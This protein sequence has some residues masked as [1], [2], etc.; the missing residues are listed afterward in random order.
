M[1]S[2]LE[3]LFSKMWDSYIVL[4]PKAPKIRDAFRAINPS[5]S[6]DHIALRTL[7]LR[8]VDADWLV[9]V[10]ISEGYQKKQSYNF[11]QKKL[12]AFHLEHPDSSLP[13]V[14]VS[15][16]L[17]EEFSEKLQTEAKL[18]AE[19]WREQCYSPEVRLIAGRTWDISYA[20]Y[21]LLRQ[22]SE[23]AAW[24]YAFG[25]CPNH[26]TISVNQLG[27]DWDL[28]K[29]NK[30]LTSQDYILNTSG[31]EIKGSVEK[32]LKQSS[33]K[34]DKVKVEFTEGSKEILG[35][36]YE[37]AERFPL[38]G[39]SEEFSGFIEGSADKIFESTDLN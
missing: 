29:V 6:N 27:G 32:G 20:T 12:Y 10:F 18:M 19:A 26:F 1:S 23:Y 15:Q 37:F 39:M 13:K 3:H 5:V 4:A 9:D 36:Y 33:T 25:L 35:C 14:F 7:G 16:L 34:A 11:E 28:E 24:L 22:E 8:G 21:E 31:G 30:M 17:V 2:T 38:P